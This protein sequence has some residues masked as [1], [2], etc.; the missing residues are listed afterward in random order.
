MFIVV[1]IGANLAQRGSRIASAMI[2]AAVVN[3]LANLTLIPALGYLG[4]GIATFATYLV[5]Y[6]TM[7]KMSQTVTPIAMRFGRAT[8]WAIGWTLVAASSTVVPSNTRPLVDVL[9]IAAAMVIGLG[10]IVQ[11]ASTV[12]PDLPAPAGGGSATGDDGTS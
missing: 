2:I 12:A 9:V 10:A 7:Y 4:A 8:G 5:A 3:T 1:Q 11:S 6:V